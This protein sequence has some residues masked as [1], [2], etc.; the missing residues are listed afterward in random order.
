MNEKPFSSIT[1]KNIIERCGVNR[2]TFYYHYES[3]P[4]LMGMIIK[5][6]LDRLV[7]EHYDFENPLRCIEPIVEYAADKKRSILH[8][9]HSV[10]RER[11]ID[12]LQKAAGYMAGQYVDVAF[13]GKE[14]GDSDRGL[15][16]AF[17]ASL[18]VGVLLGWLDKNME[19]DL[20]A[21]IHRVND[22]LLAS[23]RKI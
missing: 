11:F 9:Y 19:D 14:L 4:Y 16:T 20:V 13:V 6:D 1:V 22:L 17:Y 5:K 23:E 10:E 21:S 8:I 15:L 18:T 2:N 3:I 7:S 12:A